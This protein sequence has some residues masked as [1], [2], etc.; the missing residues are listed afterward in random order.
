MFEHSGEEHPNLLKVYGGPAEPK[1]AVT[2]PSYYQPPTKSRTNAFVLGLKI[3]FFAVLLVLAAGLALIGFNLKHVT[4]I[5]QNVTSGRAALETA[6]VKAQQSDFHAAS[7]QASLATRSFKTALEEI[8]ATRLGPVGYIKELAIYKTDAE[9]LVKS[10]QALAEAMTRATTFAAGFD[11]VIAANGSSTFSELSV[12]EKRRILSSIYNAEPAFAD[13]EASLNTSLA[14]LEAISSLDWLGPLSVKITELKDQIN[15]GKKTLSAA[16]PLTRLLPPMLGYPDMAEY[17]LVLQNSDELRPTGGFIG[18]YGIIQTKDGDFVRFETHDIY[19]ID[20]PV[21]DKINVTPPEPL[22]KY[23]IPKWYMRDSNWS[24]DWPTAAENIVRFY[25]LENAA[26]AKPDPITDFDGVIGITPDLIIDLMKLTGPVTIENVTYTPENFLDLLQYRVE[27]DYIRLGESTWQRKEVIGD[28]AKT[29]KQR[30]LDLPLNRWQELIHI[31]SD[32]IARKN[33]LLYSRDPSLQQLIREQGWSGEVR[34]TWGDFVMVVDANLAA[35]KTDAV[36]NRQINYKLTQLDNGRLK[37]TLTVNY[38]HNG[39][40]DW[41]TSHYRTYTRV[42]VP[43]GSKLVKSTGF[44][45]GP[46][47]V[48]EEFDKTYFGG[49]LRVAPKQMAQLVFEYELPERMAANMA[50]YKNYSLLVQRQPGTQVSKLTVDLSF[51]NAIQSYNPAT[52]YS[53]AK[54]PNRF[55]ADG[56]LRTDRSFLINF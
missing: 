52:L 17:L 23:L 13:V 11:A 45:E 36:M 56:D 21:Q 31:T 8:E 5:F 33:L 34:H 35:L 18:T 51:K 25:K 16:S 29:I 42:Y 44:T 48:G 43:S 24:P 6:V 32:N 7:E 54:E 46:T 2:E 38:F 47:A 55:A 3:I 28:I 15:D 49:F 53:Q 30:L 40:F 37:A 10:G 14:E 27:K 26:A 19:H 12:E 50:Q 22:K 39:T 9:H 41:K 1:P 4:A 20:I